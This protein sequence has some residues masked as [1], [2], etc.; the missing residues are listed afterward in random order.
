MCALLTL[1]L[2]IKKL[3][4]LLNVLFELLSGWTSEKGVFSIFV[5]NIH[6]SSWGVILVRQIK[7]IFGEYNCSIT[8]I[9]CCIKHG[10]LGKSPLPYHLNQGVEPKKNMGLGMST[11][12]AFRP[13]AVLVQRKKALNR[14]TNC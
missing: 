10:C 2:C 14:F 7:L 12:L 13:G 3:H 11:V 1:S 4:G 8:G 9:T 6:G 5:P